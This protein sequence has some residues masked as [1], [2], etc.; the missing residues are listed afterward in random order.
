[1]RRAALIA[2]QARNPM[3]VVG[4]GALD[5]S[6]EVRALAELLGAPVLSYRRGR[7]AIP[8]RPSSRH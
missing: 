7:G 8:H 4:G 1:M 3:I 6:E 5:A 2:A